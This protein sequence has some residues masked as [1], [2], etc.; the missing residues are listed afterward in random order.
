MLSRLQIFEEIWVVHVVHV[1]A[2]EDVDE[3][4]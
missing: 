2:R 1:R 4:K 3:I